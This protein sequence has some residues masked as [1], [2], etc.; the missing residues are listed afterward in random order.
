VVT[1]VSPAVERLLG[2]SVAEVVGRPF[3]G[4]ASKEDLERLAGNFERLRV[5]APSASSQYRL[6][7]KEGQIRWVQPSS[8]PIWDGDRVVGLQGM[9]NDVTDGVLAEEALRQRVDEL[10]ILNQVAQVLAGVTEL[11]LALQQTSELI[12]HLYDACFTFVVLA[13]ADEI[14]LEIRVG[15][16]RAA[17]AFGPWPMGLTLEEMPASREVLAQGEPLILA[18]LAS[19]P[20]PKLVREYLDAHGVLSLLLVPLVSRGEVVGILAVGADQ[21]DRRFT[22][23]QIRLAETIAGDVASAVEN[24]RLSEQAQALAVNQERERIARDLHD[25]VTQTIYSASLVAESLPRVW[26]RNPGEARDALRALQQLMR[27]GL[28]ELRTL[29]FEL[30][31]DA[32]ERADLDALLHQLADVLTG[33]T[34]ALVEVTIQGPTEL[35]PEIK[36]AL[37]RIAQEAL[38][39]VAKHAHATEV[40]VTLQDLADRVVLSVQDDGRGFDPASLSGQGLG[41]SIIHERAER[42]GATIEV[43]S[44]PGRGTRMVV[45]WPRAEG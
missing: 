26:E 39:N 30:R 44:A 19:L 18:D 5:G 4:F 25:S 17:G 12:N 6:V 8:R 23:D 29:L 27:G 31:A 36:V 21:D 9:L 43:D 33:R 20:M 13:N 37:Y 38:N 41:M 45:I 14:E 35:P 28:A 40:G 10:A 2:Y 24:A 15:F 1:Y 34:R 42:I 7:T 11:P 16:E 3:S 32:F 22:P